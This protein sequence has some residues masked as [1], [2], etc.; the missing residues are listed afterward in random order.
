MKMKSS[1][2]VK[3]LLGKTYVEENDRGEVLELKIAASLLR[4]II[5]GTGQ[6]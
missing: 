5:S 4:V 2:A 1:K 6:N 3:R